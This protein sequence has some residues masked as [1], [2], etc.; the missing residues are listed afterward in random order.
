MNHRE[1]FEQELAGALAFPGVEDLDGKTVLITGATGLIG[2]TLV[3]ALLHYGAGRENPPRVLAFVRNREKAEKL[4]RDVPKERLEFLVGDVQD[5]IS[6]E[7][8]IDYI[9]HAASVTSSKAFVGQP[10][11]TIRTA[12]NGTV[13]VLELAREKKVRSFVYLSSMEVYGAPETDEK[14]T[15]SHGTN[16]DTMSVRSSYPEGKRMCEALCTAYFA[17][18]GVP[19]KVVRLTQTFGPG[20]AYNDGRVFA[21]FARCAIEKR[22]IVLHTAGETRR[23]YLYTVDAAGAIL[24]VLLKGKSGEAYNA[25]NEATYCSILDMARMVAEKCAVGEIGV[26]IQLEAESKF[27][28]APVLK[29][30]L[31]TSKIRGLGWEPK[32]S[33]EEMFQR[34]IADFRADPC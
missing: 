1:R 8:P 29:M 33:L 5:P 3:K 27:G 16:L 2:F 23:N 18:Y 26:D 12:V 21:E 20:V 34:L 30:N 4:F 15:E 24:T 11:D 22:N 19:A 13:N 17:Q 25:A 28:Y 32:A 9:V 31:D 14:I 6:T 10:V 7:E